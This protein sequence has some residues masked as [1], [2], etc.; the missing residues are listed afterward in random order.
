[1]FKAALLTVGPLWLT[2]DLTHPPPYLDIT[3]FCLSFSVRILE[4]G[5]KLCIM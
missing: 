2:L 4:L 1:M 3:Q 5:I